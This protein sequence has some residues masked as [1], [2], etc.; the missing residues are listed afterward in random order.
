MCGKVQEW[1]GVILIALYHQ[2]HLDIIIIMCSVIVLALRD[3]PIV[4]KTPDKI[5]IKLN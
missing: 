2:H 1:R 5:I 3:I 4:S